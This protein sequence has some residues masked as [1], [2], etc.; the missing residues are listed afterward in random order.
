MFS[1]YPIL[2]A[3][4]IEQKV[5]YL[6]FIQFCTLQIMNMDLDPGVDDEF[7]ALEGK[8]ICHNDLCPLL[9]VCL[10]FYVKLIQILIEPLVALPKNFLLE[11][12]NFV[13]KHLVVFVRHLV[14]V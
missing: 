12:L 5:F 4:F 1:T 8:C 14:F 13:T 6:C 7:S 3:F 9:V 11:D 2:V 10:K